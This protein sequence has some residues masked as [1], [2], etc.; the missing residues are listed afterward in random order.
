MQ[1][2]RTNDRSYL[3]ADGTARLESRPENYIVRGL[4]DKEDVDYDTHSELLN[5][6]AGQVVARVRVD[7]PDEQAVHSVLLYH[8]IKIVDEVHRQ[9]QQHFDE[10]IARAEVHP[11]AGATIRIVPCEDLIALK[12]RALAN[13]RR[14]R[15]EA[16]RDQL[17]IEMLR[18]DVPDPNEGW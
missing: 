5:K 15:S 2:L 17:D 12:E 3:S 11:L 7:Q 4:M 8:R 16:L 6:L 18:G 10:A 14:R 1:E 9:L 13:P